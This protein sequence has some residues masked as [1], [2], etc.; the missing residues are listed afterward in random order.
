MTYVS[1]SRMKRLESLRERSARRWISAASLAVARTPKELDMYQSRLLAHRSARPLLL[2]MSLSL[3]IVE[4]VSCGSSDGPHGG[5]VGGGGADGATTG[6]GGASSASSATSSSGGPSGGMDAGAD[7]G[8]K[9]CPLPTA[10]QWTS[11]GPLASPKS[12]PGHDFVSLKDFTCVHW[13]NL[14]SVYATVYDQSVKGWNMV[15]FNFTDWPQAS[16]ASQFYM[17]SSPT[18]GGVAPTLF[19]FT[20]KKEWVLTYQ[21]GATYSTSSDPTQPQAWSAGKPLLTGGPPGAL[22]YTV[23]C[24]SQKCYLFFAGDNGNIYQS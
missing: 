18:K 20:P 6:I 19:Y 21:W 15:Y 5:A 3:S 8:G 12:P 7:S 1:V 4:A 23:I 13:N 10:F 2:T 17:Q 14:F 24:D 22:D 16:A 11:T 9:T